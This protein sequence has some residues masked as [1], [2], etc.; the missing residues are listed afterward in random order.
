MQRLVEVSLPNP[1]DATRLTVAAHHVG[2]H[3]D[4][5]AD[6]LELSNLEIGTRLFPVHVISVVVKGGGI[7]AG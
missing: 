1:L 5:G 3:Q 7:G 2:S 6:V 4:Q